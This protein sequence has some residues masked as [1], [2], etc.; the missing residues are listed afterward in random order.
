M[1]YTTIDKPTDY[2]DTNLVTGTT[3][4][5]NITGMNFQPDWIW[6]KQ[7]DATGSHRLVDS[8][9]GT[10]KS[11]FSNGTDAEATENNI[12]SFNSDGYTLVGAGVMNENTKTYAQWCWLAGG[13][14]SSNSDGSITTSV[15]ANTT[16]GF[17]IVSWVGNAT[18]N[19]TI[20]H[21]L[22]VKPKV[23]FCKN[24]TDVDSW[25]NWQDTTNDGTADVRMNLNQ[26]AADRNDHFITFGTS[27]I[28]LP[29]S[30]DNGWNGSS[31][32]M[33]G[34]CF[35]EKKG[36]SKFGSYTG[37][38]DANDGTF[39]YTGFTP[40]WVMIKRTDSTSQWCIIDNKRP[41][42]NIAVNTLF[43]NLS[44]QEATDLGVNLLSN[45]FKE[46]TTNNLGASGGT[47]VYMAFAE[48]PFVS[49]K[50]IPTTAR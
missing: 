13:S 38:G 40:A 18:G 35:A 9:R 19:A 32:N 27:T 45:G 50:G 34:Y 46:D 26:T 39:V 48:S 25:V 10:G 41:G 36:F 1:A 4:D 28:T 5:Q 3:A 12:S 16:A 23:F 6:S 37:N 30:V 33:I 20:G 29:S 49:S 22:G 11:I 17:S 21:G 14:A 15:S 43:A 31:D 8:V 2:F 24:R 47:Y 42:Y 7:R 44:D